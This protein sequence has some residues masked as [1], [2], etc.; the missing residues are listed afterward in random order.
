MMNDDVDNI[1]AR[2]LENKPDRDPATELS[3]AIS[4]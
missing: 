2:A 4:S 3:A 1:G